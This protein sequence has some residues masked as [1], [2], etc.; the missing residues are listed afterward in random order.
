ML[1]KLKTVLLL[2]VVGTAVLVPLFGDPR[3]SPV[4]HAEWARMLLRGLALDGVVEQTASAS[5]AFSTLSW[6]NSLAYRADRY[7]HGEG[8][9][10]LGDGRVEARGGPGEVSYPVAVVRGGDYRVR[11][12]LAG[13]PE[14][15]AAAEITPFGK[16]EASGQF[17]VEPGAESGWVGAGSLH[18]DPGA[19][20]ASVALPPGT[21]LDHLELAPPCLRPVEPFGGWRATAV[22]Q[23][24]DVAVTL[25]RALDLESELPPAATPLELSAEA[26]QTKGPLVLEAAMGRVKLSAG[27]EG[28]QAVV[29]VEIEDP[30]LYTLSIFGVSG[31]GQ[32]WL[33]D[34]C[35]KA[36]L[37]PISDPLA[38]PDWRVV[39]NAE[40][41]SGRH[42]FTVNLGRGATVE[43]LRLERKKDGLADY[44]ATLRRL[45]FEVG[46][47]GPVARSRAVDAMRFLTEKRRELKWS[48]CG[49]VEPP[50]TMMAEA[51][52]AQPAPP[53]A[54]PAPVPGFAGQNPAG[55]PGGDPPTVPGTPPTPVP[56]TPPGSPTTLT[57]RPPS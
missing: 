42:F 43:R 57:A 49:D 23:S 17:L 52:L 41:T 35:Q 22:T 24:A 33:A 20:T 39:M 28:L 10:A 54:G 37:C 46:A 8:V 5:Q 32:R 48:A 12:R 9:V 11:L 18:L 16:S 7:L 21:V 3:P 14:T 15:P 27:P 31:A 45:G 56:T 25:L 6:K 53:V 2:S 51:G 30:G 36:V 26:F 40:F 44:V 47:E 50:A 38:P 19:Y 13:N 1:G 34:E 4:T 55:G 29:F